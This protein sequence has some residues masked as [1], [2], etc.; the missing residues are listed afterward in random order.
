M[1]LAIGP[2]ADDDRDLVAPRTEAAQPVIAA[3]IPAARL[4]LVEDEGHLVPTEHCGA[5]VTDGYPAQTPC[6]TAHSDEPQRERRG[7]A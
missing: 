5:L 2:G 1:G 3:R 6:R 7:P 4:R